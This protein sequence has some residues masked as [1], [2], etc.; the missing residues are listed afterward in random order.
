MSGPIALISHVADP[1]NEKITLCGDPCSGALLAIEEAAPIP[2]GMDR[3]HFVETLCVRC[4]RRWVQKT[5]DNH[6][7][8]HKVLIDQVVALQTDDSIHRK[9]IEVQGDELDINDKVF[10][11]LIDLLDNG[12][13]VITK[14]G[15]KKARK[16]RTL[17]DEFIEERDF[18][19][20]MQA[21]AEADHPD[22]E[23]CEGG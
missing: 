4:F 13:L 12:G 3:D 8:R 5:N 10:R 16:M 1:D 15:K 11:M 23:E 9:V 19:A 17:I 22:D 6:D 20:E 18:E 7:D 21:L 14:K 2:E